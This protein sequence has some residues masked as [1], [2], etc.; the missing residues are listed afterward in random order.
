MLEYLLPVIITATLCFFFLWILKNLNLPCDGGAVEIIIDGNEN[1]EDL[2][3][4]ILS[5]KYV[6]ENYLVGAKIYLS[7]ETEI[8]ATLCRQH[9][10]LQKG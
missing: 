1:P 2:E 10:I 5:S 3:K 9:N 7:G 8:T 4:L 6:A